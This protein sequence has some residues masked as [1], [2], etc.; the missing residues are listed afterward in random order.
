[1][2]Q[3]SARL[4][5]THEGGHAY[6]RNVFIVGGVRRPRNCDPGRAAGRRNAVDAGRWHQ[7]PPPHAL[8][9]QKTDGTWQ[10]PLSRRDLQQRGAERP[11]VVPV[12]QEELQVTRR[13][14]STAHVRITKGV[15]NRTEVV[16][17]PLNARAGGRR[18]PCR[19]ARW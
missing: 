13:R 5:P 7:G 18:A 1:M 17:E 15:E 2:T 9:T 3:R 14:V 11:L 16:D 4:K 12:I 10:V 6:E 19:S 8:L